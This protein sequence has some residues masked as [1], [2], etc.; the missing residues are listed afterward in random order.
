MTRLKLFMSKSTHFDRRIKIWNVEYTMWK[1]ML[2]LG[3]RMAD[4]VAL[5]PLHPY[6]WYSLSYG[7]VSGV[8]CSVTPPW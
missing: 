2:I 5:P 3:Q 1:L 8:P 4:L 6:P 7:N